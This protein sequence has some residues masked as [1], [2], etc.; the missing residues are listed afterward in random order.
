M[1]AA[2]IL[3][4]SLLAL[5]LVGGAGLLTGC[6]KSNKDV[7]ARVNGDPISLT[8]LNNQLEQLKKQ[9]PNMF[10]GADAEGRLLDFKQRLL[11]NLINQKLVEQAARDKGIKVSD[12]DVKK[13]LDDLRAGFK[14]DAQYEQALKAAGLDKDTVG[15]QIRQNMITEKLI[16]SLVSDTKVS[17]ADIKA[18]YDKNKAQFAQKAAKR[19][20]QIVFKPEDKATAQKVLTQLQGGSDFAALAKQYSIDTVSASKGGDLGWPTTPNVTEVQTAIDKLAKGQLSG[21]VQSPYGWHIIK[22]TDERAASQKSLDE[23]KNQIEQIII[24]QRRADVYQKFLDD[25]RKK[26]KIEIY[27]DDLKAGAS[28][29]SK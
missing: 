8:T 17:D 7:A 29:S 21:L 2:R 14:D 27:V 28:K 12:D 10:T 5:A 15:E 1:K 23:V 26:A 18:Y 25:L 9:Y 19:V 20:S 24:N 11:D 16:A 13:K 4:V 22:V 6:K 3:L